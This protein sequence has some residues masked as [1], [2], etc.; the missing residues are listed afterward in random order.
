MFYI[1]NGIEN[2]PIEPLT[3]LNEGIEFKK[4][5]KPAAVK[6]DALTVF[7]SQ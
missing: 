1:I 5:G 4:N 7:I 3:V 6:D 2:F